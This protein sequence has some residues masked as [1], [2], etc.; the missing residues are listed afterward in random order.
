M[1]G[2]GSPTSVMIFLQLRPWLTVEFFLL[3]VVKLVSGKSL[4]GGRYVRV[5]FIIAILEF[6][7]FFMLLK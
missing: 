1:T 4:V 6:C 2:F 3:S 5:Q 7:M